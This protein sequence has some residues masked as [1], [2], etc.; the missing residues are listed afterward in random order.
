MRSVSVFFLACAFLQAAPPAKL[1]F[2]SNEGPVTFDHAAHAK[3]GKQG[4]KTC[5]DALWPRST[6]EPLKSSDGCK[7]CHKP[8]GQAFEMKGNCARCHQKQPG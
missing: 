5:H 7:T 3:R 1:V 4:C 6:R 8:G 2:P